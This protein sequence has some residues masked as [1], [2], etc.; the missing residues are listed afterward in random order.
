M[1]KYFVLLS[2]LLVFPLISA[3]DLEVEKQSSDEVM[4]LDLGN[5]AIF[6]LNIKNNGPSDEFEIYT[7]FGSGYSPKGFAIAKNQEKNI[8]FTVSPPYDD[9]RKG[10][11]VFDYYIRGSDKSEYE[12]ELIVKVI[13]LGEAFEIGAA[14]IDPESNSLGIYIKNKVNYEFENMDVKFSSAFFDLEEKVSLSP[15][16][17]KN[18]EIIL[19]KEE[20]KELTAGFYTLEAEVDIAG[21]T[22]EVQGTIKFSEKNM[23]TTS[24][25]KYGFLIS[26]KITTKSN[27]GNLAE[28]VQ[29]DM[30]KNIISRL[31]TS[32]SP[33]PD[34]TVRDGSKIQYTWNKELK[35]GEILEVKV[36]TNWLLPVIFIILIVAI[37]IFVKEYTTSTVR[38]KKKITFVKSKGGEFALKVSLMV[39]AR[40]QVENVLVIER[41]PP[42]LKLYN[43]FGKE[44]PSKVDEQIKKAE[45]QFPKLEAGE[46]R[47]ISYIVY[48]KVGVLGRFALPRTAAVYERE[49]KIKEAQSNKVYFVT[50][51]SSE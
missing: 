24:T 25:D 46:K 20:F 17:T 11:V 14:E 50:E 45:W 12:D 47:L 30:E 27:D 37:V 2:I 6:D 44:Q 41:I 15:G 29:I 32:V 4:I 48:S 34:N 18:F 38:L 36:K 5:S 51:Q 33:Q 22:G 35:P 7:F 40:K 1:K 13:T 9:S 43:K 28:V 3:I 16:E 10:T 26:T 31:F 21:E 49:G 23:V 39:H 8:Q 42:L 19:D